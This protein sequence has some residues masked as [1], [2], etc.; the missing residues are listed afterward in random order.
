MPSPARKLINS[1]SMPEFAR[2]F[3]ASS[4]VLSVGVN[5]QW[6][7]FY[8]ELFDGEFITMDIRKGA[9]PAPDIVDDITKSV[10]P[11]NIFDGA[12]FIGVYEF[13][14]DRKKQAISELYRLLKPGGYLLACI[15]GKSFSSKSWYDGSLVDPKDVF[16]IF[17]GFCLLE[18]H[19][20]YY[21]SNVP[22]YI[23]LI[24]KKI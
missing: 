17:Q 16:D 7:W 4:K 9:F 14:G 10:L 23:N 2:L 12:T 21:R 6:D 3:D 15:P 24:L 20:S 22:F 13:I 18:M 1:K 19:I 5:R 11:S 8:K